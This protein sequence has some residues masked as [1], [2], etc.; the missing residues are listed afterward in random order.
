MP[1]LYERPQ[2]VGQSTPRHRVKSN[3]KRND[4]KPTAKNIREIREIRVIRVIRGENIR[5]IRGDE[6]TAATM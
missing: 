1:R 6:I 2:G 5:V 3:G 4:G